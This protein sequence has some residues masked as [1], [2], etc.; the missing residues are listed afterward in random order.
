MPISNCQLSSGGICNDGEVV[1]EDNC[2]KCNC[3][4]TKFKKCVR[5]E[6]CLNEKK[7]PGN[8]YIIQNYYNSLIQFFCTSALK[9]E[10]YNDYECPGIKKCCRVVDCYLRCVDPY[11]D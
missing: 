4:Y 11:F 6:E 5:S 3:A 10:C 9:Q 7:K 8:C 2:Y 1:F